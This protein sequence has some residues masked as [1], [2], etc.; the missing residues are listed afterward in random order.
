MK[1]GSHNWRPSGDELKIALLALFFCVIRSSDK[2]HLTPT[3]MH[4]EYLKI[5]EKDLHTRAEESL[6]HIRPIDNSC[7]TTSSSGDSTGLCSQQGSNP[8]R[9]RPN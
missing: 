9:R 3:Q 4:A 2:N 6:L 7:F 5:Y 8:G 1:I